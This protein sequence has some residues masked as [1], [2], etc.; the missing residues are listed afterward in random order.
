MPP[1]QVLNARIE[2]LTGE[3]EGAVAQHGV[4][5]QQSKRVQDE[6]RAAKRTLAELERERDRLQVRPRA[7]ARWQQAPGS[8]SSS[9]ARSSVRPLAR[10]FGGIGTGG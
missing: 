6:L 9:M 4:L 1:W 7:H 10:E 5:A 3:L 8:S 2:E